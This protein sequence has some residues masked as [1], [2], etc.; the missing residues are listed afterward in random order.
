MILALA[1]CF[2]I[3]LE[4]VCP[5]S[6]I[7]TKSGLLLLAEHLGGPKASSVNTPARSFTCLVLQMI[8]DPTLHRFRNVKG[9]VN[10]IPVVKNLPV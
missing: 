3:N 1:P 7:E 10:Q 8:D 5:A 2:S 9:G 6:C 4:R